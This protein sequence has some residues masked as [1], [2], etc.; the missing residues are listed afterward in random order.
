MPYKQISDL[1]EGY[2]QSIIDDISEVQQE[3]TLFADENQI[4]HP[5]ELVAPISHA[6]RILRICQ[7]H[8]KTQTNERDR[9]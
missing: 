8:V 2:I 7:N 9:N 1:D 4:A 6:R 5:F 3:I